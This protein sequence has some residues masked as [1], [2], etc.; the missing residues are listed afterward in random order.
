MPIPESLFKYRTFSDLNLKWIANNSLWISNLRTLNDPFDCSCFVSHQKIEK[1][2]I[3]KKLSEKCIGAKHLNLNL[4][5][6]DRRAVSRSIQKKSSMKNLRE[7]MS[8][9]TFEA[10]SN[11]YGICCFSSTNNSIPMWAHYSDNHKGFVIEYDYE[12]LNAECA[13]RRIDENYQYIQ[14]VIYA[15]TMP[16]LDSNDEKYISK[17]LLT[18]SNQWEYENEWR[19]ISSKPSYEDFLYSSVIK[20]VYLGVMASD[21]NIQDMKDAIKENEYGNQINIFKARQSKKSFK[22]E[23]NK[24]A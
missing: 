18:K 15:P 7:K 21:K 23:F 6:D 9:V 5:R 8:D 20:A 19:I 14:E 1:R 4:N 24:I 3:K 12:K 10:T 16:Q 17:L 2:E 11:Q 13:S 22:F